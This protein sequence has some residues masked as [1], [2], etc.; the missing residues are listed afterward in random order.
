VRKAFVERG[1][2]G[3]SGAHSEGFQELDELLEIYVERQ[4]GAEKESERILS[5]S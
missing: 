2:G 1:R 3:A 4:K 5:K